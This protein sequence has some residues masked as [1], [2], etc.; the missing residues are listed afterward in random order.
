MMYKFEEKK[1]EGEIMDQSDD[2]ELKDK[3]EEEEHKFEEK[4]VEMKMM[5]QFAV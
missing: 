1:L 3:F 2:E 5:N 4:E